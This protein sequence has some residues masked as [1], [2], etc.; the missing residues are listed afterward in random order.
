MDAVLAAAA[1]FAAY[2]WVGGGIGGWDKE[3][4]SVEEEAL[5]AAEEA[6][7]QAGDLDLAAELDTRIWVDGWRG[8]V[9]QPATRVPASIRDAIKAMDRSVLEPDREVG[10][11]LRPDPPAVDRLSTIATPTLVV[12]GEL[13]TIGTRA[14]A[15]KVAREVPGAR[16]ARLPD[17]A[18]I[19]G[20]EAPDRL[21]SLIVEHLAPLPRWA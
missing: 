13:D 2:V 4:S 19:V 15:E 3:P 20:M 9:N 8:G 10:R 14:A 16:I 1:R 18:H 17:V 6:A 7:E 11:R 21:A 12:I 5:F